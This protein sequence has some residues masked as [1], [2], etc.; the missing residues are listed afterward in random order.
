MGIPFSL[1]R[2]L[3]KHHTVGIKYLK[4][5]SIQLPC[6][7]D[8]PLRGAVGLSPTRG[9]SSLPDSART[10]A[11]EQ[12][13]PTRSPAFDLALARVSAGLEATTYVATAIASTGTIFTLASTISSFG[14]G[15]SPA[16]Q[17]LA[18]D[19]YTNRR[20]QNRGE[21]GRLFGALS[22]LQALG[23]VFLLTMQAGFKLVS[24]RWLIT[25]SPPCM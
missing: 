15:F 13:L 9:A 7:P 2:V 22:V 1:W 3:L 14:A 18:L 24:D 4:P 16:V 25:L 20:A 12:R 19:I 10:S 21:V 11:S 5:T 8:E 23:Y 6:T 17:A